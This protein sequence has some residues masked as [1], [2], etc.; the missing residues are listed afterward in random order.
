MKK[1]GRWMTL[2]SDFEFDMMWEAAPRRELSVTEF[3]DVLLA[4]RKAYADMAMRTINGFSKVNDKDKRELRK[5]FANKF[6]D[7]FC[8]AEAPLTQEAFDERHEEVCDD[9]LTKLNRLCTDC[10]VNEPPCYG[11]AQKIVNMT[12]KYLYLFEKNEPI[13]PLFAFCHMPLDSNIFE[14]LKK[15]FKSHGL[16]VKLFETAWSKLDAGQYREI[17][18]AIRK[19]CQEYSSDYTNVANVADVAD[20]YA[21][22]PFYAEFQIWEKMRRE[23]QEKEKKQAKEEN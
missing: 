14:Y 10:G 22:L 5:N 18:T 3:E 1:G 8:K 20:E 7:A 15:K 23:K 11:K 13:Q 2:K 19:Y 6:I 4:V 16:N 12:F 9:F 17:Q 21:K